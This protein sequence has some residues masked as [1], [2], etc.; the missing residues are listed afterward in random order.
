MQDNTAA[1]TGDAKG[2]DSPFIVITNAAIDKASLRVMDLW[3]NADDG[4]CGGVG[5]RKWLLNRAISAAPSRFPAGRIY[6]VNSDGMSMLFAP[7]N[8]G[9]LALINISRDEASVGKR[10]HKQDD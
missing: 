1:R 6:R 10:T 7:K 9:S 5:L 8:Q 2:V 4:R 3:A